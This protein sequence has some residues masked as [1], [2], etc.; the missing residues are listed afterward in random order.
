[1]RSLFLFLLLTAQ[2]PL[3]ARSVSAEEPVVR[4]AILQ[5]AQS[6]RLTALNPCRLIDLKNGTLL[7]EWPHVKWKE[8]RAGDSGLRIGETHFQ[9]DAVLLQVQG[10][11]IFRINARPYRGDLLLYQTSQG[12]ITLVN[13]LDLEEYLVGALTSETD[14][15]WPLEALK[16]HAV[17]S[18]T[19]TAHRIW[20]SKGKA[21]DMTA[22]TGTHLYYGVAA[23]HRRTWEAVQETRGEV[24]SYKGELFS[25]TF[26]ANCGGH[27]E[28][29]SELW[30]L[31]AEIPPLKGQ[32]DPY[33]RGLRHFHWEEK[34]SI[35]QLHEKLGEIGA[36][37]GDLQTMEVLERN[38]SGRVRQVRLAG[39][40]GEQI[41]TGRRLRELLGANLLR[42]LNF[43]ATIL[44]GS[45]F[46]K[47]F[48]WGH[49]VGFCQWG[50]YGAARAGRK[51]D[52]ILQHYFPGAQRRRLQGLP[53]FS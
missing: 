5:E 43:T 2:C 10:E 9:S 7:A 52:E 18:R 34:L 40:R 17:V 16:A 6:A 51:S 33:C 26:H 1:M 27:T 25:A 42:S 50:A 38:R 21:F 37:L 24:L 11:G 47:G 49:G 32:M 19:L 44:G 41:L 28:D 53:G 48:G 31:K 14:P 29:A 3:F 46:L 39:N 12:K 13:R 35:R 22:D 4:V 8:V 15:R 30:S 20:I 23:E 45:V 36:S